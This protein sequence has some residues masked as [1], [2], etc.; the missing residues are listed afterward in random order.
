MPKLQFD[1][2][3][4]DRAATGLPITLIVGLLLLLGGYIFATGAVDTNPRPRG[5]IFPQALTLKPRVEHPQV[6]SLT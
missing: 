5:F 2:R 1:D 4:E 6:R 3:P